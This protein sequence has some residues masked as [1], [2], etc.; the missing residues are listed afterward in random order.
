MVSAE[1]FFTMKRTVILLG[2]VALSLLTL[3]QTVSCAADSAK[4]RELI[5]LLKSDASPGDKAIACKRLAIYGS[6]EAVPVLAPLL[7]DEHLAS[8]A[9]IALEAIPGDAAVE[10]LRQAVPKLQGRLL[11]GTINSIGVRRDAKALDALLP[12]LADSDSEVASAAAVALGRIGGSRAAKALSGALAK[13]QEA[14]RPAVAEGCIRCAEKFLAD[15]K[16]GDAVNLY[17]M[18][19]TAQVPKQKV[20]DATRG[21]IL[22][23]KNKGIPLLV[24]QLQSADK[25]FFGIGL[26][27]ARELPGPQATKAVTKELG[28]ANPERQPLL[29]LALAD[30]EDP[31]VM[32]T[33]LECV[34]SSSKPLQLAAVRVLD[35]LGSAA[36]LPALEKAAA[37]NES[38]VSQAALAVLARLPG[39]DVD[40]KI[41]Q[42]LADANPAVRRVAI[43][44]AGRR[45]M[46]TALPAILRSATDPASEV[47]AASLQALGAIGGTQQLPQLV[48]LLSQN[49]NEKD[50]ASIEQ[51][52]TS[53]CS[54]GGSGCVPEV[55]SL[56]QSPEK[57]VR[58]LALRLLAA[59]GGPDALAVLKKATVDADPDVQD[60]AVRTLSSWPNTW[61]EDEAVAEPLLAVAKNSAKTS[62]Q[63]LALRGYFQ[64]LEGD[65]KLRKEEKISKVKDALPLLQRPEEKRLAIAVLRNVRADASAGLLG[66]LAQDAAV[67]EDA[68]AALLELAGR[69]RGGL[70]KEQRQKAFQAVAERS[71]NEQLKKQ[72]EEALKKF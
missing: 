5:T 61:P 53:I 19:R 32:P 23:R 4:E 59:S 9:R 68:C 37:G 58:L 43:E 1:T 50:R 17:D 16:T 41:E 13:S 22:A 49:P 66:D 27:T 28:R 11:V 8:W 65:K 54:R 71:A 24:E 3:S 40:K 72:A 55:Q 39:A 33:I 20:L 70:S 7:A 2:C 63:V 69:D 15:G 31:A 18:V 64:F 52:L 46:E 48:Q 38:E 56:A 25:D 62:H 26:S 45:S 6:A 29:L 60:E 14:A 51:A 36:S 44:V 21:A 35:R 10:A 12:K 34:N 30:R 57:N 47:R 67:S 42:Q